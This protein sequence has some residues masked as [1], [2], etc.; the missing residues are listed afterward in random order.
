MMRR[1]V[2]TLSGGNI[3]EFN[4]EEAAEVYYAIDDAGA[5]GAHWTI[6]TRG[7]VFVLAN[8][9]HIVIEMEASE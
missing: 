4:G 9:A 5:R 7:N 8:I 1:L 6:P 3:V 2:I